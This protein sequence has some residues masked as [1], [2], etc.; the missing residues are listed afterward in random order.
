MPRQKVNSR[1]V[2]P[3]G[4]MADF[5]MASVADFVN[6]PLR[7]G[8]WPDSN[9]LVMIPTCEQGNLLEVAARYAFWKLP[10]NALKKLAAHFGYDDIDF[11]QELPN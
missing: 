7:A 11:E 8:K 2:A 10:M 9:G 6:L 3:R 4:A 5:E 1:G